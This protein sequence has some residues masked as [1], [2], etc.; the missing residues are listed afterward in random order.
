MKSCPRCQAELPLDAPLGLCPT[1]LV[2]AGFESR[3]PA[4]SGASEGPEVAATAA[5]PA[6]GRLA[7]FEVPS[8]EQ[9]GPLFP[10]LEIVELLGRGGMGMVYKARQ[11]G[12]DRMVAVKILP[13]E[14]GDDPAFA[15]RFTREARALAR[16]NHPH[17]V[18]IHD[19]GQAGKH[20]YFVMEF[21][22]GTNL[23]HLI[24]SQQMTPAQ[25]LAIVPQICDALQYAHDEGVV[26]R[27]IKPENILVDKKGRVKIADFGLS[28]LLHQDQ[29]DVSLTGTHQVLGT[30]RY[31]AP[32]QMQGTK[33]VDHRAD[34]Y[35]L[36][37]VFYEL[38]TGQI[39]MGRF[40]PPSQKIQVDVRL[41]QV[42]LRALAQ[43]PEKRYQQAQDVKTDVEAVRT[44]AARTGDAPGALN[45]A[46]EQVLLRVLRQNWVGA[47]RM[48]R[49]ITGSSLGEA[50]QAIADIA[51]RYGIQRP[52]LTTRQQLGQIAVASLV[53]ALAASYLAAEAQSTPLRIS[54]L[55]VGVVLYVG[56]LAALLVGARN[57]RV[58]APP[59]SGPTSE[60]ELREH[61]L[62]A[63]LR[64]A[65]TPQGPLYVRCVAVPLL[66]LTAVCLSAGIAVS[67]LVPAE[68]Q[69]IHLVTVLGSW[70]LLFVV[71][72]GLHLWWLTRGR[73]RPVLREQ[74]TQSA[75]WTSLT[76]LLFLLSC[77]FPIV[78][79]SNYWSRAPQ[80]DQ[81]ANRSETIPGETTAERDPPL[82]ITARPVSD[83]LVP[84]FE[85]NGPV[86]HKV[87]FGVELYVAGQ[88][89]PLGDF[90]QTLA[91]IP[92]PGAA[93]AGDMTLH[94]QQGTD[95]SSER[96]GQLRCEWRGRVSRHL[97]RG[98]NA[99]KSGGWV[100]DLFAGLQTADILENP[101]GGTW[102]L[103][104]FVEYV[105]WMKVGGQTLTATNTRDLL[106]TIRDHS[107]VL[108]LKVRCEPV[109]A[110]DYASGGNGFAIYQEP[111]GTT[112]VNE[113]QD[114][115]LRTTRPAKQVA[116]TDAELQHILTELP[117]KITGGLLG[118]PAESIRQLGTQVWALDFDDGPA[119]FWME[120]R[121]TGQQSFPTR[122]PSQN[123]SDIWK[124]PTPRAHLLLWIQP[125]ESVAM[126]RTL[127]IVG[128]QPA[129]CL[130]G[131]DVDGHPVFRKDYDVPV[132]AVGQEIPHPLWFGWESQSLMAGDSEFDLLRDS[133]SLLYVGKKSVVTGGTPRTVH[134]SLS[135]RPSERL[136]SPGP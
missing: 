80:S 120:V 111:F 121:E 134:L 99:I 33:A 56:Y 82:R 67:I 96:Q 89:Q 69:V 65:M 117:R 22:D 39:P 118:S 133:K 88:V 60:T 13:P 34:I 7:G 125:R 109:S 77:T 15:E 21:I 55:S 85:V 17:I 79:L 38:L 78:A 51:A 81:Q 48:H 19:F 72:L 94:L 103:Q 41:D 30:L 40:E 107:V 128:Q 84:V 35:S 93:P 124:I 119:E 45:P 91:L 59:V 14:V 108:A 102:Q 26:H 97:E 83:S 123:P 49:D 16:L 10:H 44:P 43:E 63:G 87:V 23:R 127:A 129:G 71:A 2:Q 95:L 92:P 115:S 58:P 113:K 6:G 20:F 122:L 28:K 57:L 9:L 50:Q 70:S 110:A 46:E 31:M 75:G 25:S 68:L 135:Y 24:E 29:L 32:E 76:W 64:V 27:D 47:I 62:S 36:G 130:L 105:L 53:L 86:N 61:P 42:V 37:V 4:E 132:R 12:L 52:A 90:G 106:S 112:S 101:P 74:Q 8:P 1:C 98:T 3:G 116:P 18:T 66:V 114:R 54:L 104:P 136:D 126:D 11:T 5:S 131:I 100:S 73:H